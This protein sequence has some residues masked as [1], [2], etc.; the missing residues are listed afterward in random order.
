M[1]AT[2]P[3]GLLVSSKAST[4]MPQAAANACSSTREKW[5][6]TSGAR[7]TCCGGILREAT[8]SSSSALLSLWLPTS[9]WKA[10]GQGPGEGQMAG[11]FQQSNV[12]RLTPAVHCPALRQSV[13]RGQHAA[14]QG[15]RQ[16]AAVASGPLGAPR[17][18]RRP[19]AGLPCTT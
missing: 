8:S 16:T 10:C 15:G 7:H 5:E 17:N 3:G 18:S 9:A 11:D 12:Q 6:H 14:G 1:A 13:F 2:D 19:P 4:V